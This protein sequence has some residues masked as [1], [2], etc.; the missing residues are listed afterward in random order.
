VNGEGTSTVFTPFFVEVKELVYPGRPQDLVWPEGKWIYAIRDQTL[1]VQAQAVN[2]K[3]NGTTF[4]SGRG[5]DRPWIWEGGVLLDPG[6]EDKPHVYWFFLSPIELTKK[7]IDYLVQHH[8]F[9]TL[10]VSCTMDAWGKAVH[11][12]DPLHWAAA[13]HRLYY[14]PAVKKYE[15]LLCGEE[16]VSQAFIASVLKRWIDEQS[17]PSGIP[18]NKASIGPVDPA[19]ARPRSAEEAR[20]EALR[21]GILGGY[22]PDWQPPEAPKHPEWRPVTEPATVDTRHDIRKHLKDGEPYAWLE[23]REKDLRSLKEKAEQAGA[24]FAYCV[25]SP[26]Y[27]AVTDSCEGAKD[28]GAVK[29]CLQAKACIMADLT[30]TESGK[31][32][33]RSLVSDPNGFLRRYVLFEQEPPE[34]RTFKEA[35]WSWQAFLSIFEKALPAYLG[36]LRGKITREKE[37]ELIAKLLADRGIYV[38]AT[39]G[40][41]PELELLARK[42]KLSPAEQQK[43]VH[44]YLARHKVGDPKQIQDPEVRAAVADLREGKAPSTSEAKAGYQKLR[45]EAG[46][47]EALPER[48]YAVEIDKIHKNFE[49]NWAH[50][51]GRVDVIIEMANL[52]VALR[53][54][55][56]VHK[57]PGV[58]W[59]RSLIG[60]TGAAADSAA[61]VLS[62]M[63]LLAAAEAKKR[64]EKRA[65]IAGVVAGVIDVFEFYGE[66]HEAAAGERDYAKAAGYGIQMA[67][68]GFAIVGAA[69]ALLPE[70]SVLAVFGPYGL[71]I[72]F[73]GAVF[74]IAGAAIVHYFS[75]TPN[76]TFARGCFLRRERLEE[77]YIDPPWSS[78]KLPTPSAVTERQALEQLLATFQVEARAAQDDDWSLSLTPGFLHPHSSFGIRI[79]RTWKERFSAVRSDICRITVDKNGIRQLSG[80]P[81]R[82]L[83]ASMSDG[84]IDFIFIDLESRGFD[85]GDRKQLAC[86]SIARDAIGRSYEVDVRVRLLL[87]PA[88]REKAFVPKQSD[89]RMTLPACTRA[90]SLDKSQWAPPAKERLT[91]DSVPYSAGLRPIR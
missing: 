81:L 82:K 54:F 6:R 43:L 68:S 29:H 3:W 90:S 7:S 2:G 45:K 5:K 42:G 23:K 4:A 51:A 15:E 50:V 72:A 49:L 79:E 63:S 65:F 77:G 73:V 20:R 13:C 33:I 78:F 85:S 25:D 75:L 84:R 16:A 80:P 74:V 46:A 87:D 64:L 12:P 47:L 1:V 40:K 37:R 57:K 66:F 17:G 70:S 11:V 56:E 31:T 21:Q 38:S 26:E 14:Q 44:D 53:E 39:L 22:P 32:L 30:A 86:R 27:R 9:T 8:K 89:L 60:L 76:E 71:L 58:P 88:S 19:K 91:S 61:A 36:L 10:A 55:E 83:Q 59:Y 67:G 24:Y 69:I 35:R 52:L 34:F 48:W 18:A 28:P 41:D 62:F